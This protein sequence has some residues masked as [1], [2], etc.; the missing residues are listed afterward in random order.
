MDIIG[1]AILGKKSDMDFINAVIMIPYRGII[2]TRYKLLY[3]MLFE[4]YIIR[5]L[6]LPVHS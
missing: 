3:K 1:M 6:N 5:V 4:F 2:D